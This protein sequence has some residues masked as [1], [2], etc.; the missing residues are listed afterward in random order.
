LI[1]ILSPV[2]RVRKEIVWMLQE[3]ATALLG[4]IMGLI[5]LVGKGH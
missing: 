2:K 4:V 1:K 5:R 3:Q